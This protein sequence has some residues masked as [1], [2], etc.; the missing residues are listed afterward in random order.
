[1]DGVKVIDCGA[2]NKAAGQASRNLRLRCGSDAA[3][4]LVRSGDGVVTPACPR[5]FTQ[6]MH[7]VSVS[8][9]HCIDH[10]R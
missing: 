3:S 2:D 7:S 9:D 8:L 10:A 1:M 4:C 5:T 6:S